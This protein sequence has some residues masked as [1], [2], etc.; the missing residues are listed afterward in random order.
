[1]HPTTLDRFLDRMLISFEGVDGCGKSTQL[2]L[3]S[4]YLKNSGFSVVK[5]REPGGSP[6]GEDIRRI[7]LSSNYPTDINSRAELLLFAASRAQLVRDCIIPAIKN[8]DIVLCDR[9]TDS[10]IVYQGTLRDIP[11]SHINNINGVATANLYPDLTLV[12]DL[13]AEQALQRLSQRS[14]VDRIESAE[15]DRLGQATKLASA[16]RD[17]P[18]VAPQPG[19][20]KF[21]DASPD[22]D[23]VQESVRSLVDDLLRKR[24]TGVV[25]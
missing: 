23:T 4:E 5:I 9:Y 19:R 22:V 16:Y 21:V 12:F 15:A 14:F 11:I 20:L 17:L 18:N 8:G 1:M 6:L 24:L 10:T 3:L 25:K 13:P 2:A 7:L